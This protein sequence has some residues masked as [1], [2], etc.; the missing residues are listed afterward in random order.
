[1]LRRI[2]MRGLA[3]LTLLSFMISIPGLSACKDSEPALQI[4]EESFAVDGLT[5]SVDIVFLADTHLSLC[6]ER[7]ETLSAKAAERYSFF[8]G[9]NGRKADENFKALMNYIREKDPDL[10]ILGGDIIDSAMYASIEYVEES[11]NSL[12][13]PWIYS[14]G[15]HDFE[16]GTEYFSE[17]AYNTYLPR[18]DS[19]SQTADGYQVY[20]AGDFQ[21]LA[22]DDSNNQVTAEALEALLTLQAQGDPI[23][24]VSHVPIQ[25][26]DNEELILLSKQVWGE[27]ANGNATVL[28]GYKSCIPNEITTEFINS[29]CGEESNV[30]LI[31]SG[32]IHFYHKDVLGPQTTQVITGAGFEGEAVHITLTPQ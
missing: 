27:D 9:K 10:V 5:E 8:T 1:M 12:E 14:M 3:L 17:T 7:D 13:I 4:K 11:L 25:P 23:V 31:L 24:V 6:D 32:H 16:Y 18:L 26:L 22:V 15:N 28:L 19:I 20:D 2:C 21:I 30:C 29:A